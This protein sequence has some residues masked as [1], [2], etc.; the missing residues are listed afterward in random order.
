MTRLHTA[1]R[2]LNCRL[3]TWVLIQWVIVE[4]IKVAKRCHST[5]VS[6]IM[7]DSQNSLKTPIFQ[8]K[9]ALKMTHTSNFFQMKAT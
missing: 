2:H 9:M 5:K 8:L 6:A 1:L 7:K 4:S 3:K